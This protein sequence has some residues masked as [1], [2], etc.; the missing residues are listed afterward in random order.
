MASAAP[1]P[2]RA[3]ALLAALLLPA[4]SARFDESGAHPGD[5]G[6]ADSIDSAP[7]SADSRDPDTAGPPPAPPP[8]VCHAYGPSVQRGAVVEPSLEEISGVAVSQR[9]P[10]VLWVMEDHGGLNEVYALDG[11]GNWLGKVILDG[12]EN[13]DWEDIAVHPCGDTSCVYVGDT[14]DNDHDRTY[15]AVLRFPEPEMAVG[16][17]AD[18]AL[19]PEVYPYA[20]PDG[21][22]LDSEALAILPDGTPVVF[23]KDY[24]TGTST[25]YTFPLLDSTQTV[26][27]LA[28]AAFSTGEAT[29][30]WGAATTGADLWPDG[31]RLLLRTYGHVWEYTLPLVEGAATVQALDSLPTAPR[32]AL[33]T[34]VE[35][36]GEAIGYDTVHRGYWTVSEGVNPALWYTGCADPG[37]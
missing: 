17:V 23:S 20:F 21:L 2:P 5:P 14:G 37:L 16:A 25:P 10:G 30:T 18:H 8:P 11:A 36:T 3:P 19:T 35:R 1:A 9:N 28:H 29:E 6:H 12:V 26:T 33:H 31:S 7:D 27:L 13:N 24:V 4:C 34:G 22:F 15:H 32:E